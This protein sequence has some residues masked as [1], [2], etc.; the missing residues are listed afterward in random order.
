MAGGMAGGILA[1]AWRAGVDT[2]PPLGAEL[3]EI[4]LRGERARA[5]T[6]TALSVILAVAIACAMALPDVWWAGIS[7]FIACQATA[8][9]SLRKGMLRIAGTIGGAALAFL[10]AGWLAYDHVACCFALLA[11]GFIATLGL[12]VS[13]H[14][15]AWLLCGITFGLV[16]MMSLADP[17]QVFFAAT[18]RTLE[19]M[20]GTVTAMLVATALGAEAVAKHEPPAPGWHALLDTH[21]PAVLHAARAGIA[22]ATLPLVWS[23][24]DL[25]DVTS[26]ATTMASVMAIPVL[27]DAPLDDERR[28]VT[29]AVQRFLGCLIGGGAGLLLVGLQLEDFAP[30]LA[31]L[32]VSVWVFAW[33]QGSTRGMTY[34][35]MQSGLVL[36]MTLVQGE[37]P[38]A[39]IMPGINR[40]T[41]IVLGVSVLGLVSVLLQPAP[42]PA[43]A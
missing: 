21:W 43:S 2:F 38:P 14:G 10:T 8:P 19:V 15:Y 33:V 5:A 3:A 26:M 11:G 35:G 24:F 6:M 32:F 34:V 16:V 9:A 37:G 7:G 28:I 40:L 20:V 30:F 12:T 17:T 23:L 31:V 22:V 1:M 29:R 39:S 25:P 36:V 41:G 13:P 42:K 18:T 27:A 4:R